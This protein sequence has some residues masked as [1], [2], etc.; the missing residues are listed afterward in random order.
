MTDFTYDVDKD[1]I[2]VVTWDCKGKSMNVL[3]REAYSVIEGFVDQMISDDKVKGMVITSAKK[4]FAGGM[5][6]N[7]LA[8]LKDEGGE[9]PAETIFNFTMGGHKILRKIEAPV[10]A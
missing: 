3:T 2:A 5:D 1:G 9:N 8:S 10:R 6:L 4:D 7:V